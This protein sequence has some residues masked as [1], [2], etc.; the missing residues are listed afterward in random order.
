M[1]E[2]LLSLLLFLTLLFGALDLG[3]AVFRHHVLTQTARQIS[4]AAIV[5]GSLA[6][7]LGPWGPD[8]LAGTVAGGGGDEDPLSEIQA[9]AEP[10]LVGIPPQDATLQ[11]E[12]IDGGNEPLDRVRVTVTTP[13]SPIMTFIFGNPSFDLTAQSTMQIAH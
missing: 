1:L 12:W 2:A 10:S 5:H 4:R 8:T 3:L 9:I 7:R 6:D 11:V 13:F